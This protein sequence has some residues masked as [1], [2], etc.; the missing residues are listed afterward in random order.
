[1]KYS[2]S[3][4]NSAKTTNKFPKNP[5]KKTPTK[6]AD[7]KA[8]KL[9][10]LAISLLCI[11]VSNW[12]IISLNWLKPN[13]FQRANVERGTNLTRPWNFTRLF[14]FEAEKNSNFRNCLGA[15][16]FFFHPDFSKFLWC[17]HFWWFIGICIA[18][19]RGVK[20]LCSFRL[21]FLPTRVFVITKLE[22]ILKKICLN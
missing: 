12:L 7:Y 11:I 5:G 9:F 19:V 21:A 22:F 2:D 4:V 3:Q 17:Q 14:Q 10:Y 13:E 6:L 18:I 8:I 16:Q 15:E 20:V 1:M